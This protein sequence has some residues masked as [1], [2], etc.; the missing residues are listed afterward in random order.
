[1]I[2]RGFASDYRSSVNIQFRKSGLCCHF[3][4]VLSGDI[5]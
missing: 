3:V 2:K 1:M 4:T 5:A